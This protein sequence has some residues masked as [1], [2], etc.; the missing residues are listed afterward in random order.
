MKV[1]DL[2]KAF[3]V[4]VKNFAVL[5]QCSKQSLYNFIEGYAPTNAEHFKPMLD[6]LQVI[7]D[8]IYANDIMKAMDKKGERDTM[9][10]KLRGK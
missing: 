9:I 3:G 6:R 4:N 8:N 5:C 1:K 2:A 7:S 10:M